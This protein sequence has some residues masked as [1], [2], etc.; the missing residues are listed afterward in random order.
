[1]LRAALDEPSSRREAF[2]RDRAA[3]DTALVDEVLTMLRADACRDAIL[4]ERLDPGKILGDDTQRIVGGY[5]LIEELGRGGMG[6][7]YRAERIGGVSKH[8]VALKIIK[9]GMDSDEIVHRFIREREILAQL[10]HP[11]IARLIDG[12]V[13]DGGQIWFAMELVDGAPITAWCDTRCLS[14]RDRVALFLSV[15]AAVQYA[16][17]NLVVH[18]DLKPSNILVGDDGQAKLLDF[19]IAKLLQHDASTE[20]QTRS[21][22][23]LLTP[24]FAAPEQHRGKV[25]TTA[26]DVYQLGL[27]LYE[28]LCGRRAFQGKDVPLARMSTMPNT[29]GE[30]TAETQRV[31]QARALSPHALR[32]TLRGD[33]D[34]IVQKALAEEPSRRYENV[35]DFANDL[36]RFLAGEAV[37]AS[38]DGWGYRARKFIRRHRVAVAAAAV[39]TLA[40]AGGVAGT[41]W[42]ARQARMAARQ[43]IASAARAEQIKDFIGSVF[44]AADPYT[45]KHGATTVRDLLDSARARVDKE[46]QNQ[47]EVAVELLNLLGKSYLEVE[48]IEPALDTFERALSLA[49]ATFPPPHH[50][51]AMSRLHMARALES[52]MQIADSLKMLDAAIFELRQLGNADVDELIDALQIRS[53]MFH[54]NHQREQAKADAN[55]AMTLAA[56]RFGMQSPEYFVPLSVAAKFEDD[57]RKSFEMLDRAYALAHAHFGSEK[58]ALLLDIADDYA[59][60]LGEVG[61]NS[62][63]IKLLTDAVKSRI[64]LFGEGNFR[65]AGDRHALGIEQFRAGDY[66]G[67]IAN[68]RLSETTFREHAEAGPHMAIVNLNDIVQAELMDGQI[69]NA[70]R[71]AQAVISGLA[72]MRARSRTWLQAKTALG[73]AQFR[74]ADIKGAL[75]TLAEAREG[76]NALASTHRGAAINA[77]WLSMAL[78]AD[79]QFDAARTE[80]AKAQTALANST[81]KSDSQLLAEAANAVRP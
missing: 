20:L 40:V 74:R 49:D 3:G 8:H 69:E 78:S 58:S 48:A 54:D 51:R 68:M 5:R 24:E 53:N 45:S 72:S 11:N 55:E 7:V 4:D 2:V 6:A 65:V 79:R 81:F 10:K 75:A 28:L 77:L 41:L 31:A 39:V 61:R 16:H 64:E 43:A 25:I 13:D 9:R 73:A 1:L 57:P 42:Q 18:R 19:G 34:R 21:Q 12:G 50:W 80:F 70:E 63:A 38:G 36:R 71:D 23:R 15:C 27:V 22:V 33:L 47:P 30:N 32:K 59:H 66:A 14:I 46:L 37:L 76:W 62:D 52:S 67:A 26:T 44:S 60:A 35:A 56:A 17:R 29:G